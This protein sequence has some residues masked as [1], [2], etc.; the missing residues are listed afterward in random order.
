MSRSAAPAPNALAALAAEVRELRQRIEAIEAANGPRD[1]ADRALLPAIAEAVGSRAFS[2]RDLWRH[3]R[4]DA[5]L[6]AGL[7]AADVDS[8]RSLG[9]VLRRLS[10]TAGPI[11]LV[12]VGASRDGL[13]WRCE[14]CDL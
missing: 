8:V 5:A 13:R 1:A 12:S 14:F 10:H 2:A 9:H 4:V 3:R 7:L 11:R 6:A